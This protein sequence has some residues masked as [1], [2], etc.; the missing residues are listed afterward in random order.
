M[1]VSIF[2]TVANI[3]KN[4]DSVVIFRDSVFIFL[5]NTAGT[6]ISQKLYELTEANNNNLLRDNTK[7]SD[8]EEITKFSA[9]NKTCKKCYYQI[10]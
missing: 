10:K 1:P 2:D 4:R 7:F 6:E 5:T 8:F 9:Y 3:L